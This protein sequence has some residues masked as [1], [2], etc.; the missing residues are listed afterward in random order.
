VLFESDADSTNNGTKFPLGAIERP[1]GH[2]VADDSIA[3]LSQAFQRPQVGGDRLATA[4][5][6]VTPAPYSPVFKGYG[7]L[8]RGRFSIKLSREFG[9]RSL[10]RRIPRLDFGEDFQSL[11]STGGLS[12]RTHALSE[13]RVSPASRWPAFGKRPQ[14]FSAS[15]AAAASVN[16]SSINLTISEKTIDCREVHRGSTTPANFCHILMCGQSKTA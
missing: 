16:D 14:Q 6:P 1:Q 12:P 15:T 11:L 13:A 2:M 10:I 4:L 9:P 7:S 3:H 5:E 8:H